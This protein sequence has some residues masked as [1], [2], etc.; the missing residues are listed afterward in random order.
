MVKSGEAVFGIV[1]EC[2]K[3]LQGQEGLGIL[4]Y[5]YKELQIIA[6]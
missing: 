6:L 3:S 4:H 5:L 1:G 2:T